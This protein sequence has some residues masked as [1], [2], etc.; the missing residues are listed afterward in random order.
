M[1]AGEQRRARPLRVVAVD[2]EEFALRDT[3]ACVSEVDP[4]A[5][6]QGFRDAESAQ[7]WM[8]GH[9][10]DLALL[11]IE[12]PGT[13]GIELA[14]FLGEVQPRAR[15]V[16]VTSYERYALEAF[17]VHAQGYLLKPV[18]ADAL[19]REMDIARRMLP[20]I[21]APAATASSESD[22]EAKVG[23]AASTPLLMAVTFGGFEVYAGGTRLA[24]RR[25]RAKEL[26]A[27]LIDRR[28]QGVTM[29]EAAACLWPDD[30]FDNA[31]RSYYQ[32]IVASL[33]GTL[34]AAGADGVLVKSWNSLA[35]DAS[36]VD[37]DLYRLLEGDPDAAARYRSDYLPS[38]EWAEH[39]A[40]QL[41][42]RS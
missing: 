34:A 40:A 21:S 7:A 2:D 23:A 11:D 10:C 41:D 35:V 29:R 4:A 20:E 28:G 14:A 8:T 5:E 26:L 24:F 13:R 32:S 6:I 3:M 16:F 22:G 36:R 38:Y 12:M 33:R 17:S 39:T 15:V 19:G 37:C 27:L 18:D 31:K 25:A 9:P 42:L 1:T 30:P